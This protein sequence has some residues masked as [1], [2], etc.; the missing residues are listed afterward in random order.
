M[1]PPT[2][3][4]TVELGDQ[5][6]TRCSPHFSHSSSPLNQFTIWTMMMIKSQLIS[7]P[8]SNKKMTQNHGAANTL[9]LVPALQVPTEDT[10]VM[11]RGNCAQHAYLMK[12]HLLR[13]NSQHA[14]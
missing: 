3:D 1:G 5:K 9:V 7:S 13:S 11:L 10:H 8:T 12:C 14:R 4:S 2:Y 6:K